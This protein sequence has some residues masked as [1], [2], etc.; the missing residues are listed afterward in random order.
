MKSLFIAL[1]LFNA[2]TALAGG[3]QHSLPGEEQHDV[4]PVRET[5]AG[6]T[7]GKEDNEKF[8]FKVYDIPVIPQGDT[9]PHFLG[10]EIAG[11]WTVVN[12][13]YLQKGE[14]SIGFGTSYTDI[15][16]PAV[17]NA[18]CRINNYYKKAVGK[19]MIS[20]EDARVQFSRILDC[21]IAAFHC[22]ETEKFETAL[23][24]VRDADQLIRIFG[25]VKIEVF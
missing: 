2:F 22:D 3:K 9:E 14:I 12:E 1:L 16:K 7:P 15:A 17:F 6:L 13:L 23:M 5:R 8:I 24:K 4:V 20:R 18:V 21:T 19:G 11:K 10:D 25:S